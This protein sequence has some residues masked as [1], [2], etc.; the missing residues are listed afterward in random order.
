MF[1]PPEFPGNSRG[2]TRSPLEVKLSRGRAVLHRHGQ[3]C[4]LHE[5][6]RVDAGIKW[7]LR[8][9]VMFG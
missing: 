3:S 4:M 1:Y 7:V 6:Q 8:S 9:D 2:G 5:G